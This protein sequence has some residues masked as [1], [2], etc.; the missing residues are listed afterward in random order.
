LITEE[1]A[2]HASRSWLVAT[3][4]LSLGFASPDPVG[5][6][7]P[8]G[9]APVFTNPLAIT[10]PYFPFV[11][12]GV[13]VLEGVSQGAQLEVVD[14]YLATTRTF[15]LNGVSVATRILTE[16]E[17]EDGE[18]VEISQ[19]YF[20][21]ADDGVVYYFGE[22]VDDY[23]NGV[24]VGHGGSWLVG[25]PTL[26]T[27]PPGAATATVPAVFMAV[28]PDEGDT[29]KPEDLFPFVDETVEVL[30]VGVGVNVP[31]GHFDD[32]LKVRET[33]AISTG[34]E[35]KWYASGVGVVKVLAGGEHLA[36]TETSFGN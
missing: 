3:A 8:A 36:L 28:D 1:S 23:E 16:A 15:Q 4:F 32:C 7:A 14:T 35:I 33:S 27:D 5:P 29:W 12:G 21:Q 10:N 18:V 26:P 34:H 24:I 13:K 25:G 22:V 11:V 19:N 31:A 2:M 30:K 20:A 9:G 17:Y 6:G